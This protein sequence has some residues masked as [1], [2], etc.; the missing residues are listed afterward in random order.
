MRIRDAKTT[1]VK[2]RNNADLVLSRDAS[3]TTGRYEINVRQDN[4]TDD[5]DSMTAHEA[6]R[7][8]RALVAM[9]DHIDASNREVAS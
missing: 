4:G 7:F 5:G 9:A 2:L 1:V 3:I 8:A 6:R